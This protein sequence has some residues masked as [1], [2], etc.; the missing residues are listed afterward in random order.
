MCRKEVRKKAERQRERKKGCVQGK[1]LRFGD[2]VKTSFVARADEIL[3]PAG[4]EGYVAPVEP[5]CSIV[6]SGNIGA[7]TSAGTFS[8]CSRISVGKFG[9]VGLPTDAGPTSRVI[10]TAI[11]FTDGGSALT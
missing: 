7:V 4:D 6:R 10:R 9:I 5:K 1:G 11:Y 3:L 8:L 2:R